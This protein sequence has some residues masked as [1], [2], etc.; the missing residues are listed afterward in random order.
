MRLESG[1]PSKS[2]V[3]HEL[4]RELGP[5]EKLLRVGQPKQGR[6]LRASDIFLIPFSLL[7]GG[8][9]VFFETSVVKS[10]APFFFSLWGVPFVLMGR[11]YRARPG[12]GIGNIQQGVPATAISF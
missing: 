10:G 11:L 3:R 8:F 1:Q 5:Q 9:A 2:D 12:S 7:W 6:V 4:R